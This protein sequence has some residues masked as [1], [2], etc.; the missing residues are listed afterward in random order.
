MDV[1]SS[2]PLERL[3]PSPLT[4]LREDGAGAEST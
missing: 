3:P 2:E 4:G 1:D